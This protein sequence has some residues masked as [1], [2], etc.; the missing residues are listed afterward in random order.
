MSLT[1]PIVLT[2]KTLTV[3]MA[4]IDPGKYKALYKG[5]TADGNEELFLLISHNVPSTRGAKGLS[6]TVKLSTV[7][8]DPTTGEFLRECVVSEQS[9][10]KGATQDDA[11]MK[12]CSDTLNAFI[13]SEIIAILNTES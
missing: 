11:D 4:L 5:N 13:D 3:T 2:Y 7:Q 1:K 8:Y 6:H 10:T 12:E 9:Y